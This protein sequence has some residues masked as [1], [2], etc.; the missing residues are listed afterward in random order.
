M[1]RFLFGP[2]PDEAPRRTIAG[3]DCWLSPDG[4]YVVA[5]RTLAEPILRWRAEA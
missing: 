1:S 3:C 4:C 2:R 5:A